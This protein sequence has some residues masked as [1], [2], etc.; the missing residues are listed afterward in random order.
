MLREL[1]VRNFTIIDSLALEL[2]EGLTILTGETGAGKSIIV[3]ALGLLLGERAS[4]DMIKTGQ[5]EAHVEAFFDAAGHQILEELAIEGGDGIIVRRTLSAQGKGRAFVNDTPVSIQTLSALVSGFI[6]IHGQHEHQSLL[7]REN[8]LAY[9]DE[10]AGLT[11]ETAALNAVYREAEDLRRSA[12]TMRERKAERERMMEF[13]R[14]QIGEIDG[15]ALQTGEK[16][17]LEEER[18]ILLN[19]GRLREAS[20]AAYRILYDSDVSCLDQLQKAVTLLRDI[21]QIDP[22]AEEPLR[23]IESAVP[24]VED[25]ALFLRSRRERY[26]VDPDRLARIDDRLEL[27]KKLGRK[28]GDDIGDILRYR[29]KAAGELR[30]LE[31]IDERLGLLEGDLAEKEKLLNARAEEISRKRHSFAPE[32]AD[33][34][35]RELRDLGFA[36]ADFKLEMRRRV[37][38]GPTGVDDVEFSFSANPGEPPKPLARVVS[39]GELSRIMLALK[40]IEILRHGACR[41]PGGR[42]N[43]PGPGEHE[44]RAATLIFDEVDAG[45]G[46]VTAQ[47]VAEKLKTLAG[48]YQVLCITHLPQIAAIADHHLRVEKLM[49]EGPVQVRVEVLS[50]L[51][52]REE[53]AR[54]LSGRLTEGALRHAGELLRDPRE[55]GL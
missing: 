40:C 43:H 53:L 33:N 31:E 14:F 49:T 4:A 41:V 22:V 47:R 27:L 30:E 29:D 45:V 26:E 3:D 32:L 52:R 54:M 42:G 13:L 9:L 46:G 38:V 12:A 34:V 51:A 8:H 2:R 16:E 21:A 11:D 48:R 19:T 18:G 37:A 23:T 28:Y 15:A 10:L 7:R 50:G 44:R 24:H 25:T 55:G 5:K 39:G 20:E 1:R 35:V 17:A 36:Q 6:D